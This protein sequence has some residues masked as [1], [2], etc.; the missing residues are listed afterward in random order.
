MGGVCGRVTAE[1]HEAVMKGWVIRLVI[2]TW[3]KDDFGPQVQSQL[4]NCIIVLGLRIAPGMRGGGLGG[5]PPQRAGGQVLEV[6]NE[7]WAQPIA[8]VVPKA[9]VV[10]SSS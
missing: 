8:N 10:S 5:S 3:K 1:Q 4:K 9:R 7:Q 2:R 6:R